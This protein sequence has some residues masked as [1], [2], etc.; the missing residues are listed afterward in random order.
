MTYWFDTSTSRDGQPS[1]ALDLT[2]EV[3]MSFTPT[4]SVDIYE[5]L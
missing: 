5:R 4:L 3:I 1:H 2:F